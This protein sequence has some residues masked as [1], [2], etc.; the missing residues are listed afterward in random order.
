[1]SYSIEDYQAEYMVREILERL[2]KECDVKANLKTW[3]DR[4]D[5]ISGGHSESYTKVKGLKYH[6]DKMDIVGYYCNDNYCFSIKYGYSWKKPYG[7]Y[8]QQEDGRITNEN[9]EIWKTYLVELYY[10]LDDLVRNQEEKEYFF[11]N[12][13]KLIPWK[14]FR[15][16]WSEEET[17]NF[18]RELNITL[19]AKQWVSNG[20]ND[21]SEAHQS[22]KIYHGTDCVYDSNANIF[23]AGQWQNDL[24]EYIQNNTQQE[25]DCTLRMGK[26]FNDSIQ[27]LRRVRNNK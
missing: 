26:S 18:I 14:K 10:S 22:Y 9:E 20:G 24:I 13:G 25:T 7:C 27:I 23:I 5:L 1:M 17:R 19:V 3:R 16:Y 4:E 12:Y 21:S 15:S 8:K 2:G 6:F 11:K